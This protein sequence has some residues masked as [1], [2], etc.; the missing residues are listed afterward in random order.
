MTADQSD[1]LLF[2]SGA[3]L[4]PWIWDDVVAELPL[5]TRTAV[6]PR[7]VGA[8]R[9]LSA[10]VEHALEAAPAEQFTIVAHSLGAITGLAVADTALDRAEGLI[11]VAGVVPEGAGSFLSAMPR[12]NRWILN[13]AM[14]VGG[15][16]PPD[17]AIRTSLGAGLDDTVVDRL[18]EEFEPDSPL[19]FRTAVA[20]TDRPS[21]RGYVTSTNDR[22]LP[23]KLQRR[24]HD[25][26]DPSWE[27]T[28]PTGHLPMLEDP[29]GL[30]A[31]IRD[32]TAGAES[33]R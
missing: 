32:F 15:T 3:G 31:A 8:N 5:G 28:L 26:L 33:G 19:L 17:K 22:E 29:T 27:T 2:I 30:A 21:R 14:R 20:R 7:P 4:P 9:P 10:Y 24:F 13:I 25:A 23:A 1:A 18:V 6:A 11:A 16:R 12:P